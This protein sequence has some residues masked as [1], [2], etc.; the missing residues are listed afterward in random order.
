MT[1]KELASKILELIG[2]KENVSACTHCITRLRVTIKD[3]SKIKEAEIQKLPG[4]MGTN[5]VETQFQVILGPKVADVFFE[6]EPLVGSKTGGSEAKEKKSIVSMLLDTFTGIFTP[7]LPAII[8]AGLLKGVL[9]GLMFAGALSSDSEAYKILMV[10]SDAAYYFLPMLLAASTAIHFKC[11]RYVAMAVA[12]VMIHPDMVTMLTDGTT[13]HLL[14]LPITSTTYG[15]TVL[16]IILTVVA[17]SYIEKFLAKIVPSILRTILVPFCTLLITGSLGLLI[18][19]PIGSI[20]S[21]VIASN[22][23]TFYVNYG[24]IAGAIF[25]GLFPLMVLLGIHNGFT[26]VMV[27]CLS[28]Y[29]V[30]YLMGLNV[31][32]N[33]AQAGATFAVSLKT[34]NKDFKS[35]SGTAALNAILGITEP[36]LYGVTSKLKRPL[37]G[38]CIGGAVGGAIAGFFHVSATGMATGPIIGIPLFLTDTFIW[39]VVSCAVAFA[40]AFAIVMVMGFEDVPEHEY[41]EGFAS[42]EKKVDETPVSTGAP[43]TVAGTEIGSPLTGEV[44]AL[45]NLKDKVFS[46]KT[47]GDGI[48]IEPTEGKVYAPFDGVITVTFPTKHCIGLHA[49]NGCDVLIHVGMDTVELDGKYFEYRVAQNQ[50]VKKG[51]LLLEFDLTKIVEAGYPVTT[52][53]IITNTDEYTAIAKTAASTISRGDFLLKAEV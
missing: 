25:S 47:M 43:S 30:E 26:P 22:F 23:L 2:G 36:A 40:V 37:I 27:Q 20:V 32:S 31:A 53:V 42:D 48:A 8:G 11:N 34:K 38:V 12:G 33:S 51:D 35:L 6:F 10:F 39:F 44:I 45:E 46:S 41:D 13:H 15:S 21:N 28:T 4:V 52:P 17:M 16:P 24:I 1:N 50:K 49:E 29:G 3:F 9:L 5:T 7:I 18:L 19:G 14:G